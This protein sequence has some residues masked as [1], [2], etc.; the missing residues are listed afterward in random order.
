MTLDTLTPMLRRLPIFIRDGKIVYRCRL[1]EQ[2]QQTLRLYK[3]ELIREMTKAY[4]GSRR[5][6]YTFEGEQ[7]SVVRVIHHH[8]DLAYLTSLLGP[9]TRIWPAPGNTSQEL[10]E[11]SEITAN[12]GPAAFRT[13]ANLGELRVPHLRCHADGLLE[14]ANTASADTPSGHQPP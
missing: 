6:L 14:V 13:H 3:P 12:A 4:P 10:S 11:G 5:W 7:G 2:Q 9:G 1:T 8:R